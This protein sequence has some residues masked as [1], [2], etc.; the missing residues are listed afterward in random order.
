VVERE[1]D[2][3][4]GKEA[5]EPDDPGQTAAGGG[6]E[7]EEEGAPEREQLEAERLREEKNGDLEENECPDRLH[8]EVWCRP[9]HDEGEHRGDRDEKKGEQA[10]PS[11]QGRGA[12]G[13]ERLGE[14]DTEGR[15]A[16][17]AL[18]AASCDTR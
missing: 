17:S 13:R 16:R 14:E 1:E 7:G 10:R 12:H 15:H 8:R 2:P 4:E 9:G 3:G 5:R 18:A 6:G 11:P